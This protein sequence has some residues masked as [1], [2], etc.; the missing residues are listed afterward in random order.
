MKK[1]ITI[2]SVLLSLSASARVFFTGPTGN[3]NNPGT[4]SAPFFTLQ[5]AWTVVAAGDTVYMRGGTYTYT[6]QQYLTGKN[7]TAGN[8]INVWAYPNELPVITRGN[9]FNKSAGHHRGMVFFTGNYSHWRG[10]RFTGMYTDDN[11]VDDGLLVYNINNCTFEMLELDN[12]VHGMYMQGTCTGNLILNCD[13]HDN[14]SNYGGSNGGNSD[15]LAL[16]Y[17]L[18]NGTTNTI[19]GCRAWNNG[20]D[21]FDTFENL[22]Y[23]LIENCWAWHNGYQYGTNTAAGDGVGFKLGSDFTAPDPSTVKRRVQ[24]CIAWDN[25]NAG[26][27]INEAEYRTEI[28]NCTFYNNHILN[29]NFDY[30]NRVHYFKNVIS[31]NSDYDVAI[32]PN[33]QST[34]CSYGVSGF[35]DETTNWTNNASS[36]DFA[37]VTPTGVAGARQSDG[38]LPIITFLHLVTGSDLKDAGVN[39]GIAL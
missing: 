25:A 4:I 11:Q 29:M 38:S 3:D 10:I 21:G 37:S 14:Y 19:R 24:N 17:M 31:F 12:N 30:A 39:V 35:S 28:Y 36:A 7:G 32:S 9:S 23:V 26:I 18:T 34:T 16:A 5:K 8:T 33:S 27:H 20:D 22:G 6:S 15:G 1:I 2:L 13:F